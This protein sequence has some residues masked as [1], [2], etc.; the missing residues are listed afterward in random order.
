MKKFFAFL[1]CVLLCFSCVSCTGG[2]VP[3]EES[4]ETETRAEPLFVGY[5]ERDF[6]PSETG[7]QM[8]GASYLQVAK[9]VELPLSA[10]AVAFECGEDSL[11]LISMDIL[12]FA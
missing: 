4:S 12:R 6:T 3:T 5:A 1:F 9:R 10:S 2:I 11:I 7:G 8:P